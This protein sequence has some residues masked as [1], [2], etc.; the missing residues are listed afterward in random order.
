MD[1][2]QSL[3]NNRKTNKKVGHE[4]IAKKETIMFHRNNIQINDN[5]VNQLLQVKRVQ[6]RDYLALVV[7]LPIVSDMKFAF[8]PLNRYKTFLN[9][10][11]KSV[12]Y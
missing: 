1:L 9:L 8:C 3:I 7:Y 4:Q 2:R 12:N 5:L 11:I 10:N 6:Q